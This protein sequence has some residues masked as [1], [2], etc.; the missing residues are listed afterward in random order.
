MKVKVLDEHGHNI[1]LFGLGLSHGIT[2]DINFYEFD[3]NCVCSPYCK[4]M[5]QMDGVASK[6]CKKGIGENKFL[7]SISVWLDITAPRYWWQQFDTYRVGVTKQSGS[8]MHTLMNKPLTQENFSVIIPDAIMNVLNEQ[9]AKGDLPLA[10]GL[11][12]ESFLQRRVVCTNYKTLRNI[13]QQRRDHK[14]QEWHVFLSEL[15]IQLAE[16]DYLT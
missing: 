12:P 1:A 8:T 4:E 13:Y 7:E 15:L 3:L 2:S 9:I 11:L 10:K 14:L 16:P 6:L 5:Q